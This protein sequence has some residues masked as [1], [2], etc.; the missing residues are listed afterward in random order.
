MQYAVIS[1]ELLWLNDR[2]KLGDETAG[3]VKDAAQD[4]LAWLVKDGIAKLVET[5][6]VRVDN[7]KI[8][9]TVRIYK[10]DG[11]DIPFKFIWDAQELKRGT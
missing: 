1:P 4:A 3:K 9:L 2:G 11:A 7:T 8:S 5:E 6:A 10:P